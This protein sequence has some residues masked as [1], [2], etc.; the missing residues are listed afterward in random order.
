MRLKANVN[1]NFSGCKYKC[2]KQ[3]VLIVQWIERRPPKP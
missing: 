2:E 3:N 1:N